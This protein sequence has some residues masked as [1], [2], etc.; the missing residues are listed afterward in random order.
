MAKNR[1]TVADSEK[2]QIDELPFN[3]HVIKTKIDKDGALV[4]PHNVP[5]DVKEWI[6][7]LTNLILI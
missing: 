4:F 6:A 2:K 5:N 7:C 3:P 1:I